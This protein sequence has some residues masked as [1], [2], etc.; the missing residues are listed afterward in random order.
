V[1]KTQRFFGR[2]T[3]RCRIMDDWKWFYIWLIILF[4][5]GFTVMKWKD[6]ETHNPASPTYEAVP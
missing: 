6:P 5:I 3:E 2:I 1:V 4:I